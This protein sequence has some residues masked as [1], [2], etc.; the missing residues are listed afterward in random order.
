M[1]PINYEKLTK[2]IEGLDP[3]KMVCENI[4]KDGTKLWLTLALSGWELGDSET[5][6]IWEDDLPEIFGG[7][8]DFYNNLSTSY[9]PYAEER[10]PKD[11]IEEALKWLKKHEREAKNG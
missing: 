5:N 2:A 11:G 9:K 3:K 10:L 1:K 6:N 7:Y 4:W 8:Y